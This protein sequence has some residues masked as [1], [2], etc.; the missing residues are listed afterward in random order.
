M[1]KTKKQINSLLVSYVLFRNLSSLMNPL[2][3]NRASEYQE[4]IFLNLSQLPDLCFIAGCNNFV[5]FLL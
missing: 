5:L 2:T 4:T 3:T 1:L